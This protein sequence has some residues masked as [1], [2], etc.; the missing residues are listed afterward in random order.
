MKSDAVQSVFFF[1]NVSKY[2]LNEYCLNSGKDFM[3]RIVVQKKCWQT[4]SL[5]IPI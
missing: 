5:D 3:S 1:F 2:Q 4:W